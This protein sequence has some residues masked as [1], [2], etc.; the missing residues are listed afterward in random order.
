MV[1][2]PLETYSAFATTFRCAKPGG[3]LMPAP[4]PSVVERDVREIG[5]LIAKARAEVVS[6]K[7]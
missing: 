4:E 1:L 3:G 6:T 2:R 5:R 7:R